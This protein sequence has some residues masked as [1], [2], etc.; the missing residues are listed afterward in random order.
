MNEQTHLLDASTLKMQPD[1]RLVAFESVRNIP[2]S[3]VPALRVRSD[4]M[5]HFRWKHYL[6]SFQSIRIS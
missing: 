3:E 5:R 4:S 1:P 6:H 2:T